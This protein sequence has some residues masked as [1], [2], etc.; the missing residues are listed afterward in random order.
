MAAFTLYQRILIEGIMPERA[1]LRLKRAG[2]AVYHV[3]KP[4]K[5]QILFRVKKKDS[6][7]VFA[8]Y[9]DVCYNKGAYTPY[10]AQK[11]PAVGLARQ[12]QRLKNRVGLALGGMLFCACTLFA[13]S[14]VLGVRL[15]GTEIYTREAYVALEEFGI[16][17]FAKYRSGNEDKISAKLLA[18]DGV[19]Y[20]SVKKSGLRVVVE[21]RLSDFF[22][23]TVQTGDMTAT[24]SGT[25]LSITALRGTP[26]KKAGDTVAAGE[27]LVGGY[28]LKEDGTRIDVA[29]VARAR[30]ACTY[31]ETWTAEDEEEAFAQAYLCLGLSE[32]D[33][34]TQKTVEKSEEG[35]LVTIKYTVV[36]TWNM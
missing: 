14:L 23:P 31:A 27:P 30:I 22:T 15:V 10:K 24:W 33:E 6:E 20:C 28:F 16:K 25:V 19:E 36:Q 8:I 11:L 7:K 32:R 1:L 13:D 35:F 29:P 17:P 26:L 21:M 34:I 4:Q 9:P 3:K 5:N 18:L 2:I 12:A